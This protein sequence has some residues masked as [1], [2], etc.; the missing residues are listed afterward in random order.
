MFAKQNYRRACK[1]RQFKLG[2]K[3]AVQVFGTKNLAYDEH[4]IL[5]WPDIVTLQYDKRFEANKDAV[6][7]LTCWGDSGSRAAGNNAL[8]NSG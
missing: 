2:T 8:H 6:E 3:L 5:R 7:A 4:K 1:H